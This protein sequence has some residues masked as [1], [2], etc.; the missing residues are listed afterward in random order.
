MQMLKQ[1][2]EYIKW[3]NRG[4]KYISLEWLSLN[5]NFRYISEQ[6]ETIN[7]IWQNLMP[8]LKLKFNVKTHL[9]SKMKRSIFYWNEI[10]CEIRL[11]TYEDKISLV[12]S[13]TL[14]SLWSCFGWAHM[15]Y[16]LS[17]NSIS[18]IIYWYNNLTTTI[19]VVVDPILI[20][21][22]ENIVL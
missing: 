15:G 20:F 5:N 12:S 21:F 9:Y 16:S 22:L 18:I 1:E 4:W 2:W 8:I 10:T 14:Y 6:V 11:L 17:I 3:W 19:N 7:Y 13:I